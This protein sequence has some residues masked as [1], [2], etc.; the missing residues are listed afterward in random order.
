M[1][2]ERRRGAKP[3]VAPSGNGSY[4]A[5][6]AKSKRLGWSRGQGGL[7]GVRCTRQSGTLPR[8]ANWRFNMKMVKSLLL[9]SAA[10]L[11]AVAGAQAADMPVKAAAVQY[12]KICSLYGDGF[13]YLPGTDICVK[14]GGYVRAELGYLDGSSTTF[15]PFQP[16]S[17]GFSATTS[18]GYTDRL[19]GNDFN[20]R[21]RAYMSMDTRQQTEYGV[22]RTY[23][24]IGLNFDT[25]G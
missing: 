18:N 13:Y 3:R 7:P 12:V 25:G 5:R 2:L 21:S 16:G 17:A 1:S 4:Q 24:N 8:K 15:G 20:F 6:S 22:L 14:I 11:V 10:G 23:L 19:D 9:G